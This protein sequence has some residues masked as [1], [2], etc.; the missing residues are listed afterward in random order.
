MEC[1][2]GGTRQSLGHCG[3][4]GFEDDLVD[5]ALGAFEASAY[6]VGAG[7]VGC[8]AL[9][10]AAGI[11]QQQ[12]PGSKGLIV[13]YVV[14]HRRV[15]PARHD[16]LIGGTPGSAPSEHRVESGFDFVFLASGGDRPGGF[17]VGFPAD[18]GGGPH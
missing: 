10:F 6:G 13:R 15:G 3:L 1:G 11:D 4:L 7:D 2:E 17:R 16:G 14:E 5:F 8:V 18:V 9:V 12:V